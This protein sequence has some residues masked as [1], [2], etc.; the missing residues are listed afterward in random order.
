MKSVYLPLFLIKTISWKLDLQDRD[1]NLEENFLKFLNE[2][3]TFLGIGLW[4]NLQSYINIL[5]SYNYTWN[6]EVIYY[7]LEDTVQ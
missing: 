7:K 6:L 5:K 1:I 3:E 2:W 4:I